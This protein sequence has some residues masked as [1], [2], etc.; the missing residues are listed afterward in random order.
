MPVGRVGDRARRYRRKS[1]ETNS[2]SAHSRAGP[3]FRSDALR[4]RRNSDDHG[5]RWPDRVA[6]E[7]SGLPKPTILR[8]LRLVKPPSQSRRRFLLIPSGWKKTWS[9]SSSPRERDAFL[10]CKQMTSAMSSSSNS[11]SA[12]IPRPVHPKTSSR[13]NI[14]VASHKRTCVFRPR[15]ARPGGKRIA[16]ASTLFTGR[17]TKSTI[18]LTGDAASAVPFID[19]T[20][21]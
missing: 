5:C 17:P 1:R 9:T 4:F 21:R 16:G 15:R 7:S 6:G 12:A 2:P 19:W 18:I 8:E 14:T 10:V 20:Y 11:G 3:Q 13:K